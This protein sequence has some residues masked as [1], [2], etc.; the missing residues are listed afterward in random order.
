MKQPA[1]DCCGPVFPRSSTGLSPTSHVEALIVRAR[2]K[3][4]KAVLECNLAS[5][6]ECKGTLPLPQ[7]CLSLA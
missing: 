1:P 6:L 4:G 7:L 5:L 3:N 2:G